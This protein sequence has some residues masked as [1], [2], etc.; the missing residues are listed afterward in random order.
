[1]SW[2][3]L[4]TL[5]Y[6]DGPAALVLPDG[7]VLLSALSDAGDMG[8]LS[9]TDIIRRWTDLEARMDRL[10]VAADNGAR[11]GNVALTKAPSTAVPFQPFR[12]FGA[13]SNYIEHAAEM[14]TKLA[15]KVDSTPFV[16]MKS[17]SSIIGPEEP[18][19]LPPESQK[20]DWEV[21]LGVVIGKAGRRIPEA[22]ALDHVAGYVVVNDISARDLTRRTDFPFSHDWFRGKSFDSF[23][24]VGPWFVPKSCVP[25]LHR[26]RLTLSVNGEMM[27]DGTSA[28]MIFNT[29]EQIAYLSRLLELRP[30]D[31]L[32]TGTPAGVGMAR[33][34]FLKPGDRMVAGIEHVGEIA[35]PVIAEG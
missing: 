32:A 16:F 12:I 24:P 29:F 25:D 28:D 14:E 1:M 20:V 21:E 9:V 30:T 11:Q 34:I 31:L 22:R 13:A 7:V 23:T 15:A 6:A 4:A 35:N 3:A 26:L 33:G 5:E 27:Q 10:A 8:S 19:V 17:Q 2:Y 18:V